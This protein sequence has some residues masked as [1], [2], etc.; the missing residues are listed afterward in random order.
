VLELYRRQ[1]DW[2]PSSLRAVDMDGEWRI[3]LVMGQEAEPSGLAS[4]PITPEV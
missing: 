4:A 2:L 3:I 1:P